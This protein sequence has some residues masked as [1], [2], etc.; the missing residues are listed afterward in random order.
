[1][2]AGFHF[3]NPIATYVSVAANGAVLQPR[4]GARTRYWCHE[5]RNHLHPWRKP[6]SITREQPKGRVKLPE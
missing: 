6:G 3:S 2:P 1:M 5:V 4:P